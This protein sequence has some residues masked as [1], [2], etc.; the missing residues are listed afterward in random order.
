MKILELPTVPQSVQKIKH[1][2]LGNGG[3]FCYVKTV[4]SCRGGSPQVPSMSVLRDSTAIV[5]KN[6]FVRCP[7]RLAKMKPSP[8]WAQ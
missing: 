5:Y 4:N 7:H 3:L 6:G 8:G 1:Q 2:S